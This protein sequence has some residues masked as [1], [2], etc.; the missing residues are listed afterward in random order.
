MPEAKPDETKVKRYYID[1]ERYDWVIDPK[2]PEKLF[3][4]WREHEIAKWINRY[5]QGAA[6]LDL[7]CG[8]G[9]ITRHLKNTLIVALDIN[10]WAVAKAKSYSTNVVQCVA[11][12]AEHLPLACDIFDV[13]VCTD[14]LEH[15]PSPERALGQIFRVM[16]PGAILIGEVPSKHVVW[17]YRTHLTSTCP[18][19]E[20][21]HHNY[22][23]SE[24]KVM[25]SAFKMIKL[26]RG[27]FGL[28]LVFVAQKPI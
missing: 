21:F 18:I 19:S 6:A 23:I 28:E 3:H 9:L 24:L 8:T 25:L 4:V 2:Y 22:S 5:G 15:L 10:Q 16:K 20:P 14:V 17:K 27:S 12:D 7:G 13:V 1:V 26:C 11:G